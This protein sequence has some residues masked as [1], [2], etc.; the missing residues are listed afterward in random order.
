MSASHIQDCPVGKSTSPSQ[1]RTAARIGSGSSLFIKLSIRFALE[2]SAWDACVPIHHGSGGRSRPSF[3]T[4]GRR[5]SRWK[6]P[7]S[8]GDRSSG[9][10]SS[11]STGAAY[12]GT[13]C[14]EHS[15][16]SA[17]SLPTFLTNSPSPLYMA[18][19]DSAVAERGKHGTGPFRLECLRLELTLK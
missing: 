5:T 10:C 18:H 9:K 1:P 17:Q 14:P 13:R 15:K 12:A 16:D 6:G 8:C 2:D 11:L 3:G 19:W 7:S 4:S